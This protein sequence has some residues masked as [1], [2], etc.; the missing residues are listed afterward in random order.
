[1][2]TARPRIGIENADAGF[3]IGDTLKRF[4]SSR[5][6]R[7]DG[8]NQ[9]SSQASDSLA[10]LVLWIPEGSV[11]QFRRLLTAELC[12]CTIERNQLSYLDHKTFGHLYCWGQLR[13]SYLFL[14]LLLG[15][16]W[17]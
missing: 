6:L 5:G 10:S 14:S 12:T 9:C 7:R 11:M 8:R 15:F 2:S 3:G 1:M 17:E 13:T 16:Q 4:R